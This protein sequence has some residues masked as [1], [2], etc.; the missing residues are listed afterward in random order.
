M[1]R[2]CA[3]GWNI[4]HCTLYS[5]CDMR[6]L[7]KTYKELL[8]LSPI[9][10]PAHWVCL[11]TTETPST[12]SSLSAELDFL[13][14]VS[15]FIDKRWRSGLWGEN[16][17]SICCRTSPPPLVPASAWV[18]TSQCLT[19]WKGGIFSSV[20]LFLELFWCCCQILLGSGDRGGH[21][22]T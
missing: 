21:V 2:P 11:C 10:L 7:E 18:H 17:R 1:D 14:S 4:L 3:S 9:S 20:L 13:P 5:T 22:A 6:V 19:G 12:V 8:L 15:G 16:D